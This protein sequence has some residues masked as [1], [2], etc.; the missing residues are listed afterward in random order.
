MGQRVKQKPPAAAQV[1]PARSRPRALLTWLFVLTCAGGAA[2]L[3]WNL[4]AKAHETPQTSYGYEIVEVYPHDADAFTQG[5]VYDDGVLYEGTGKYGESSLRKVDLATGRV[6]ASESLGRRLFGEGVTLLDDNLYQ[7]TWKAGLALVYHKQTMRRTNTLRYAGEG[8][9]LTH[10]GKHLIL[11][12]GTS[13]L[14]Y[15]DPKTFRVVRRL[16]VTSGGRRVDKLNE[17]E[18]IDGEIYANIWYSDY[19]VRISP[20]TGAITGWIDL[21]GLWPLAKRPTREHVLNGIAYD[22]QTGHLLVTGKN[23]PKLF[24]IKVVPKP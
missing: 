24:E 21:R 12:D 11:S 3:L 22:Q 15:V 10:D 4:L 19:I 5:L 1:Q 7:L 9:G 20:E 8:W 6:L 13:T 17:L 14:R 16:T 2:F 18:Y 23:W